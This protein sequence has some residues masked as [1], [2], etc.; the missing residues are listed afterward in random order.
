[1]S[2]A[3]NANNN[4][5]V[6]AEIEWVDRIISELDNLR[7]VFTWTLEDRPDLALR[8]CGSL[9]YFDTYWLTP[10]EIRHW[11]EPLIEKSRGL[12]ENDDDGL[13]KV[14]FI[15][16]LIGLSWAY[17]NQGVFEL[18]I[19]T[20]EEAIQL[21]REAGEKRLLAMG[22][23]A[24][25]VSLMFTHTPENMPPESLHEVEQ[26][27]AISRRNGYQ[28]ELFWA[29]STAGEIHV[30]QGN[31]EL[32]MRY[33][34]EV[35]AVAQEFNSPRGNA[36]SLIIQ[37]RVGDMQGNPDAA[38]ENR[39]LAIEALKSVKDQMN[40]Q[41]L[42]SDLAHIHRRTGNLEEAEDLYRKTIV[43]WQEQ[44]H[45]SAV[46]HQLECFA[47]LAIAK[48]EYTH[49][50]RLLG[51]AQEARHKLD[52]VS[53]DPQEI[54]ELSEALERLTEAIGEKELDRTMDT[55]RLINLDMA[56]TLALE[57]PN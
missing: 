7:N 54:A 31:I 3:E 11:L 29:L 40:I 9:F 44:G 27:I 39:S 8:I 49:A 42:R 56:V 6:S 19:S 32:G 23:A 1:V 20:L 48:G 14:D 57:G 30:R 51:S 25:N 22:L 21:S 47:F 16:I 4:S 2:L 33:F 13:R 18:G 24:K 38:I 37:A 17:A 55:G 26:A 34:T 12:L 43:G 15:Q 53:T 50:A 36:A 52:S 45:Q 41:I 28:E 5:S 35:M 10:R 46:A